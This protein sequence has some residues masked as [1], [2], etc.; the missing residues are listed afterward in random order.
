MQNY[1]V[2]FLVVMAAVAAVIWILPPTGRFA[3]SD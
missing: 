1:V 2:L 3:L